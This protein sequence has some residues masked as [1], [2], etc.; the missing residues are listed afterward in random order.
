MTIVICVAPVRFGF[1]F[2]GHG[3]IYLTKVYVRIPVVWVGSRW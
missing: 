1:N 3:L 2:R